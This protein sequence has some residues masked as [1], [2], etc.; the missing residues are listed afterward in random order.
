MISA[1]LFF[2]PFDFRLKEIQMSEYDATTYE[3]FSGAVRR[4]VHSLRIILDNLQVTPHLWIQK[5]SWAQSYK[6]INPSSASQ[7]TLIN[8]K[9]FA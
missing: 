4:Q 5:V 8:A 7:K 9:M 1:V 6:V 3:K 2:A